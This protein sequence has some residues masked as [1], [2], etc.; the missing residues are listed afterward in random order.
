MVTARQGGRT[1][2]LRFGAVLGGGL[3]ASGVLVMGISQGALAASFT[4]SGTS[5]KASADK[6]VGQ[7]YAQYGSVDRSADGKA[8]AVAVNAIG[9]ASLDNFC[10]SVVTPNV[11]LLGE[12][13]LNITAGGAGGMKAEN[14]LLN[15]ESLSGSL[16]LSNAEVGR[17][18]ATLDKGPGKG[19]AGTFGLQADTVTVTG[20]K[21]TAWSTTASTL[22]FN[23]MN[24]A[25]RAGR[26]EC[27]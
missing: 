4:V 22:Q 25:L 9:K 21:Q 3:V 12:I 10:Q 27:F 1:R 24:L 11:P 19:Q 14:L 15:A 2:W 7:G 18:A 26:H 8:H 20:L 6:M 17:D 16:T 23:G 5:F 13:S